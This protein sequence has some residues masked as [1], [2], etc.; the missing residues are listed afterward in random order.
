[1]KEGYI[2]KSQENLI[3]KDCAY[4]TNKVGVCRQFPEGKPR[5]VFLE[6]SECPRYRNE[7]DN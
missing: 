2:V 4:R 3:C 5:T 7:T 6:K 1:M